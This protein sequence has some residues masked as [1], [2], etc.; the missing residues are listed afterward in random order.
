MFFIKTGT[1]NT[2]ST[3]ITSFDMA[4]NS[5]SFVFSFNAKYSF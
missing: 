5:V 2:N 3:T 4:L 1:S